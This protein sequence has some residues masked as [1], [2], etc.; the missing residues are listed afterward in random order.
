MSILH[1]I[2]EK[3]A[4]FFGVAYFGSTGLYMLLSDTCV[5]TSTLSPPHFL[6]QIT[7]RFKCP[8]T[9]SMIDQLLFDFLLQRQVMVKLL[10]HHK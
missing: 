10:L 9:L 1:C 3:K 2:I 6:I 5:D 8:L 4:T 7:A